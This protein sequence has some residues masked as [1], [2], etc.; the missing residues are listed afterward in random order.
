MTRHTQYVNYTH[1]EQFTT[2]YMDN[3]LNTEMLSF[4]TECHKV[5]NLHVLKRFIYMTILNT[6]RY[7][8]VSNVSYIT[9]GRCLNTQHKLLKEGIL[10]YKF[11]NPP[12]RRMPRW[13]KK[14]SLTWAEECVFTSFRIFV[15]RFRVIYSNSSLVKC[16][17]VGVSVSV[18]VTV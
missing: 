6:S 9:R 8:A 3:K 15:A 18:C 5:G 1:Y 13:V 2:L 10:F 14:I 11:G 17:C 4:A 12:N 16:R 7:I